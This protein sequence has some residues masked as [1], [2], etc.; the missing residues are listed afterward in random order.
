MSAGPL[1][2][3][4][5]LNPWTL[6]S[7]RAELSPERPFLVWAPFDAPVVT[8][9]YGSLAREVAAVAVGL[10]YRGVGEGSRLLVHL[11]NSPEFLIV[12]LACAALGATAVTT[13][14]R[15]TEHELA[16]LVERSG[17]TAAVTQPDLENV[18]ASA[19]KGLDF[20]LSTD[21]DAGVAAT[22]RD[23]ELLADVRG[24]PDELISC[25]PRWDRPLSVHFTSGTTSQPKGVVW[26]QAN[27]IWA[28][29][30][31]AAHQ[32][33]QP[34]DCH[35]AYMPLFHVNALGISVLASLWV[36][37]RVVLLP[38]WSTSRF[39]DVSLRHGCTWLSLMPLS[40]RAVARSEVP[41]GHR[42]RLFGSGMC[43]LPFATRMGAKTIG[44]WGMTETISQPVVGDPFTPNRPFSIGRPAPEY[45]VRVLAE[46][47]GPAA[48]EEPGELWVRGRRGVSLF[49]GY[50]D[51]DVR[52]AAAFD[53]EGWF[54]TGDRAVRHDDG[55]LTFAE[56]A[57]DM[58]RVGSENVAAAE[59][60]RVVS[61]VPGVVEAAVVGVPDDKLD[62][63]PVAFVLASPGA[64]V[65]AQVAKACRE[66]L[67]AFK[68]PREVFVVLELP[69]A[70]LGKVRK[71]ALRDYVA[72]PEDR[73]SAEAAWAGETDP[74]D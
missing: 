52:T 62:E 3:G 4:D 60:E 22:P 66:R 19:G 6:L 32:S 23:A 65:A 2:A 74:E 30:V 13:N 29:R 50:L 70:T 44:W 45:D 25:P 7:A 38:K 8:W 35:L 28:A 14:S 10:Q 39:W 54:R 55:H 63:V 15:S 5:G 27:A 48:L 46:D 57:A 42:Y 1:P 56:R 69:R 67:A 68:H 73:A 31:N 41:T 16:E 20:L 51:D 21:H 18:V 47:G 12:W 58:L 71:T 61:A 17:V 59:I 72:N 40:T 37:A 24:D 43:D 64:D 36:G 33:L 26:T 34:S 9:T 53:D 49:A 11:D